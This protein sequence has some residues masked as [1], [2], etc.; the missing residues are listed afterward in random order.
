V[1]MGSWR[2]DGHLSVSRAIDEALFRSYLQNMA[3]IHVLKMDS[4]I[5]GVFSPKYSCKIS[6]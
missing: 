5:S 1:W 2:V 6:P 3:S 4:V